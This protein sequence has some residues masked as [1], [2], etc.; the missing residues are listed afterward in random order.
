MIRPRPGKQRQR[1]RVG[2]DVG[3][4][5]CPAL[6]IGAPPHKQGGQHKEVRTDV[7]YPRRLKLDWTMFRPDSPWIGRTIL[8]GR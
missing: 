7:T 3:D 5:F 2:L 4:P 8:Y 6:R 1:A